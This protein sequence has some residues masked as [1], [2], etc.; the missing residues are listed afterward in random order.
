M[1]LS[2][3]DV[4]SSKCRPFLRL[5]RPLLAQD[6][7]ISADQAASID[8]ESLHTD[9]SPAKYEIHVPA[10]SHLSRE[11]ALR[12]HLTTRNFFAWMFQLPIVGS[13]LGEALIALVDRMNNWRAD[14]QQN[15]EEI[16]AYLDN[17]EYTDFR[18]CP[19][20]SLAILQLAE[21]FEFRDLWT[22]AFV[23]CVGM[24]ENLIISGEF[25]VSP[26]LYLAIGRR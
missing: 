7:S 11:D 12:Y 19:D 16:L 26:P 14:K 10:P 3:A 21:R 17:Q 24:N 23:H 1:R 18:Q 5:H 13:R 22:D 6:I 4:K 2:L 9:S 15:R 8:G 20:H 25:E